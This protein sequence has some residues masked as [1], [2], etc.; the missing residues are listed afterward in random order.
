MQPTERFLEVLD[1][2]FS[3]DGRENV[4]RLFGYDSDNSHKIELDV[5]GDLC[6]FVFYET[7]HQDKDDAA[8]ETNDYMRNIVLDT[9]ETKKTMGENDIYVSLVVV[10]PR[11][12][13]RGCGKSLFR[14]LADRNRDR[15]YLYLWADGTCNNGF[16]DRM[17]FEKVREFDTPYGYH[18]VV[19]RKKIADLADGG[20][21]RGA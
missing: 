7:K 16:Y 6:G 4:A 9:V 5:D 10:N 20:R 3:E 11:F 12:Q 21:G 2:V 18:T 8:Y 14:L 1:E 17:A 19:Y 13:N 15:D